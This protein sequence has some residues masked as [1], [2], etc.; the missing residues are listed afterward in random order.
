MP[1]R[2]CTRSLKGAEMEQISGYLGLYEM[3]DSMPC[4]PNDLRLV[5]KYHIRES[6]QK[7]ELEETAARVIWHSKELSRWV[8]VSYQKLGLDFIDDIKAEKENMDARNKH[9]RLVWSTKKPLL[10]GLLSKGTLGLYDR[11]VPKPPETPEFQPPHKDTPFSIFV[12]QA[13]FAGSIDGLGHYI[14]VLV[15][16]GLL[17]LESHGENKD[18]HIDVLYPTPELIEKILIV[19]RRYATVQ[20]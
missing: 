10:H 4:A 1:V 3:E 12:T 9:T 15:E 14:R 18:G 17:R 6:L 8:G 2:W 11:L 7:G 13:I 19:E 5:G 16:K 20:N